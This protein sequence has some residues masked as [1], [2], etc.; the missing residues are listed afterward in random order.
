MKRCF[1]LVA[2]LVL[3]ASGALA[4]PDVVG[5]KCIIKGAGDGD[6]IQ[7]LIFIA[8]NR[9]AE[10]VVVSDPMILAFNDG[11][12]VT[13]RVVT[14][15]SKRTTFA[16]DVQITLNVSPVTMGFRG[17]YVK[18]NGV[19]SV[20]ATPRGYSNNFTRGGTC[21]VDRLES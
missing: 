10:R 20:V 16:W 2:G 1:G 17:T 19:F 8:Y 14:D 13:G 12:P 11:I 3:A 18:S 4:A 21:K 9:D 6:W 5:Y 15:N 7:P